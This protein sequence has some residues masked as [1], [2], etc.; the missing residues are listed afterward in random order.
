MLNKDLKVQKETSQ[1]LFFKV[2]FDTDL[3]VWVEK[4]ATLHLKLESDVAQ[5]TKLNLKVMMEEGSQLHLEEFHQG[6]EKLEITASLTCNKGSVIE[7]KVANVSS[8]GVKLHLECSLLDERAEFENL[9]VN[10]GA[11]LAESENVIDV[12]HKASNTRS[13]V[14]V[15]SVMKDASKNITK[16]NVIVKKDTQGVNTY[17]STHA[18]LMDKE[19]SAQTVPALEIETDDVQAGHAASVSTVDDEQVFY[20]TTRGLSEDAAR[21]EIVK[22]FLMEMMEDKRIAQ[23]VEAQW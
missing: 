6:K 8:A 15:K 10:F 4:D 7:R 1:D 16:G 9:E 17:L 19:A 21:K 13:L 5:T 11:K 20:L 3:N 14:N 12:F 2:E 22:G 23:L 18:L